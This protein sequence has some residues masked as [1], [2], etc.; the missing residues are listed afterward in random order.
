MNKQKLALGMLI[1]GI[2]FSLLTPTNVQAASNAVDIRVSSETTADFKWQNPYNGNLSQANLLKVNVVLT[3]NSDKTVALP[4]LN[5]NMGESARKFIQLDK[6][7]YI[8]GLSCA[9]KEGKNG[10]V[11]R[12]N[13]LMGIYSLPARSTR[14]I[15]LW[16]PV[17][18]TQLNKVDFPKDTQITVSVHSTANTKLVQA[19][20]LSVPLNQG[21][22]YQ[23]SLYTIFPQAGEEYRKWQLANAGKEL[24]YICAANVLSLY[25][26]KADGT[27]DFSKEFMSVYFCD[28]IAGTNDMLVLVYDAVNKVSTPSIMPRTPNQTNEPIVAFQ[29]ETK[30]LRFY[31][32]KYFPGL[33]AIRDYLLNF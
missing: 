30:V 3:N 13:D 26:K 27:V 22:L 17:R 10:L 15:N 24:Q 29:N 33:D 23:Q 32:G 12:C 1:I 4:R 14:S 2:F 19:N 9:T 25:G 21:L 11:I 28:N 31:N 20:G 6:T 5:F 16:F 7:Q 8:T 18:P